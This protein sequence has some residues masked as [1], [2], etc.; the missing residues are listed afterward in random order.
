MRSL[1]AIA[2]TA[3]LLAACKPNCG[4]PNQL[5]G[6]TYEMFGNVIVW[7][8]GAT[9]A[10]PGMTPINGYTDLQLTWG[11]A[12]A[13]PVTVSIDGQAFEG[14]G[15]W[16]EQECGNFGLSFGGTF[17]SSEGTSHNF[18]GAGNFLFYDTLLEGAMVWNETWTSGTEIGTLDVEDGAIS[19]RRA[20]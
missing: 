2:S 6:L 11:T 10:P 8:A 20:E 3:V 13:G 15:L 9:G 14:E 1:F 12:P 4:S 16:Q 17:V 18:S 5:D 7:Q 19:G